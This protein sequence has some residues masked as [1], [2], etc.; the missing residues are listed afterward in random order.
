MPGVEVGLPAVLDG[1]AS[2]G[3]PAEEGASLG[4]LLLGLVGLGASQGP[5]LRR[6]PQAAHL[7]PGGEVPEHSVVLGVLDGGEPFGQ[8]AL[9]EQDLT[10]D[11]WEDAAV[12]EQVAQV[13]DGSPRGFLV[14]P[15]VGERDG[16]GGQAA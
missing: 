10:V 1:A 16:A 5:L 3:E 7:V 6:G 9:I 15:L 8:P 13:V 11:A 2:V 14:Q 4:G 12:H